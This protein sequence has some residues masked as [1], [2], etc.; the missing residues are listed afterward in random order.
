MFTTLQIKEK[1]KQ[2]INIYNKPQIIDICSGSGEFLNFFQNE[3]KDIKNIICIDVVDKNIN[4][5]NL[6][7]NFIKMN[8]DNL[9]FKDELFDIVTLSNSLH[10][11]ENLDK[12]IDEIKRIIKKNGRI[13]FNEMYCDNLNNSQ[14]THVMLHHLSSDID[15]SNNIFH[16]KTFEREY[17]INFI[18]KKFNIINKYDYINN[19]NLSL[20]EINNILDFLTKK[21]NNTNKLYIKEKS[22]EIINNYLKYG[23]EN[24][25]QLFIECKKFNL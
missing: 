19:S 18:N 5:E 11:I 23:F 21:S 14:K 2:I 20:D 24:A 10:H 25:T 12:T 4:N 8:C 3:L 13:I 1:F 17:I 16:K 7:T 9:N 22:E 15:I 6:N